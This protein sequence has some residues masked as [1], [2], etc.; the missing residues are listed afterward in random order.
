MEAVLELASQLRGRD[1]PFQVEMYLNILLLWL[2]VPHLMMVL[3]LKR[4]DL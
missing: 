2:V 3:L 4:R 1:F